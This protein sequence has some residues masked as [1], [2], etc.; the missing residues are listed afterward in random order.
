MADPGRVPGGPVLTAAW[1]PP[2]VA[3]LGAAAFFAGGEQPTPGPKVTP[4]VDTFLVQ[5]AITT[6][7][8]PVQPSGGPSPGVSAKV[9]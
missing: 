4:A 8:V 3:G 1:W 6:G 7:Q 9:P 5:H 2:P